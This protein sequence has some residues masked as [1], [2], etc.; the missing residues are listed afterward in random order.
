MTAVRCQAT[1]ARLPYGKR[2]GV[3][4]QKQAGEVYIENKRN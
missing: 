2:E 4:F 1:K 3:T